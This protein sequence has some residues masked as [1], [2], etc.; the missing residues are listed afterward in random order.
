VYASRG[1]NATSN[2][3]DGVF[4]DGHE[5]EMATVS[6]DP[7]NRYTALLTVGIAI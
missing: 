5:L 7:A 3:R 2:A 4:S 1:L 6:G